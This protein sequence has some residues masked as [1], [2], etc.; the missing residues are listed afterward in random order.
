MTHALPL[1][2][3]EIIDKNG[4]WLRVTKFWHFA[5]RARIASSRAARVESR[6]AQLHA[7]RARFD[8]DSHSASSLWIYRFRLRTSITLPVARPRKHAEKHVAGEEFLQN[9]GAHC[10]FTVRREVGQCQHYS[11]PSPSDH[12]SST[13]SVQVGL[14]LGLRTA[15][16]HSPKV[17]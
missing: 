7:S 8:S 5:E 10:A 15:N 6:D 2:R 13:T 11:L 12:R 9:Y 16:I 17:A 14:I 4:Q 3:L 1:Y